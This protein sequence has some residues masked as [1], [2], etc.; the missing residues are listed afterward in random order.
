[1]VYRKAYQ[2]KTKTSDPSIIVEDENLSKIPGPSL[3][4]K[5]ENFINSPRKEDFLDQHCEVSKSTNNRVSICSLKTVYGSTRNV[6]T[7]VLI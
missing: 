7:E 5:D 2:T 4:I 1:M 6:S 3:D